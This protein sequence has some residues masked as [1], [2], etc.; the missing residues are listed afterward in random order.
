MKTL[1]HAD[2][3]DVDDWFRGAVESARVFRSATSVQSG[4]IG[5]AVCCKIS[6][7]DNV[8]PDFCS[9]HKVKNVG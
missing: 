6:V 3:A 8:R 5:C 4:N 1:V 9:V 7:V 2:V